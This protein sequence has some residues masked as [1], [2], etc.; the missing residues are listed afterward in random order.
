MCN[1]G[2]RRILHLS[3][4]CLLDLNAETL[5]RVGYAVSCG[6]GTLIADNGLTLAHMMSRI[7]VEPLFDAVERVVL[8]VDAPLGFPQEFVRSASAH[9]GSV[10]PMKGG[11]SEPF[12]NNRL[13]FR[14]TDRFVFEMVRKRP[15]SPSLDSLAN[16]VTKARATLREATRTA[17]GRTGTS[18]CD[19]APGWGRSS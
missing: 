9:I 16:N 19:C 18:G 2:Y 11:P 14:E 5:D 4:G 6:L 10:R 13:A 12:I 7:G 3:V 1:R 8:A 15:L 17:S